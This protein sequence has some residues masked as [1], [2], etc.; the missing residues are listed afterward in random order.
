MGNGKTKTTVTTLII[1]V[2]MT[3]LAIAISSNA[4]MNLKDNRNESSYGRSY[5][6]FSEY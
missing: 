1:V 6:F 2:A 3:G 5:I 4:W